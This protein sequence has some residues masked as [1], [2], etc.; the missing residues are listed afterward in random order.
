ME[1]TKGN[2]YATHF[3]LASEGAT[4]V[5]SRD[6]SNAS[7]LGFDRFICNTYGNDTSDVK[8]CEANA[9][10]IAAAPDLLEFAVEMVSRYSNSPWIYEQ[11][12]N[13]IKKAT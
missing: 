4:R 12:N 2:W 5:L 9:K 1:Y 8:K 3:G 13:A 7:K 11:G 6:D 10:L